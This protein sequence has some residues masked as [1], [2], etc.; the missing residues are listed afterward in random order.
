MRIVHAA[1]T[2]IGMKR[3]NNE[4]NYLVL[5]EEGLFAVFDGMGGHAAGEVASGIA[6]QEMTEFFQMTGRD[7]EATW[8]FK[9]DREKSIESGASC[10]SS[11]RCDLALPRK[12]M[13]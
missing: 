13:P 9:G 12:T 8:P 4:D 5:P 2:D 11:A 3:D 6:V 10:T 1:R 7:P